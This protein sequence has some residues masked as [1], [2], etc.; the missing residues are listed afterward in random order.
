MIPN[1]NASC[2]L[3]IF[4]DGVRVAESCNFDWVFIRVQNWFRPGKASSGEL[5]P[6]QMLWNDL[7]A[8]LTPDMLRTRLSW[9]TWPWK[10]GLSIAPEYCV[11]LIS[12]C[13]QKNGSLSVSTSSRCL[14]A[15]FHKE[16]NKYNS[17]YDISL[18]T[19]YLSTLKHGRLMH[20]TRSLQRVHICISGAVLIRQNV[21]YFPSL[22]GA[23]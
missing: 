18:S 19:L 1:E 22:M 6:L 9:S 8:S 4:Q 2:S 10:E 15:A 13:C 7:R 12:S 5:S 3:F 17:F 21:K 23:V 11:C 14:L 20:A 16:R